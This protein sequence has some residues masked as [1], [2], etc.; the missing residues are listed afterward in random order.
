MTIIRKRSAAS[1]VY[2]PENT[3]E[4]QYILVDFPVTEA[5]LQQLQTGTAFSLPN[6]DIPIHESILATCYQQLA[7]Q[8]FVICQKHN[9]NHC[10]VIA[11]DKLIRIR[12]HEQ[13]HNWQTNEQLTYY[14]DPRKHQGFKTFFDANYQAGKIT[15]VFLASGDQIRFKAANLHQAVLAVL[16]DFCQQFTVLKD[17][18]RLHDH[19]HITYDLFSREKNFSQSQA[20]KLRAIEH[21]YQNNCPL[22]Q[23]LSEMNFAVVTMPIQSA[24]AQKISLDP[25]SPDPYNPLY[26]FLSELFSQ[27]C[28]KFNLNN[29][30]LIANGLVPIVRFSENEQVSSTNE[31]QLFGFNPKHNRSAIICRWDA[32]LLMDQYQ[33]IFIANEANKDKDSYAKF[34]NQIELALRYLAEQ[35]TVEPSQNEIIIRFHQHIGYMLDH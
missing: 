4:N 19:Q 5:L 31:L 13:Q 21:R 26:T 11:N 27:A 33:L 6:S 2:L 1:K 3:R 23:T 8:L 32:K 10:L 16:G 34:L 25:Q 30:V 15:L 24:L 14:Y 7:Q 35:L 29:G 17:K 20:H 22:P 18:L 12:Y 9:I 28:Q